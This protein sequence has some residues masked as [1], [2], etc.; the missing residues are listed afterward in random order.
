[1][2]LETFLTKN[3]FDV[4]VQRKQPNK[5]NLMWLSRNLGIRNS[6]NPKYEVA[7]AEIKQRLKESDYLN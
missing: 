6:G 4:P 7:M 2:D 3:K 5:N 1:M